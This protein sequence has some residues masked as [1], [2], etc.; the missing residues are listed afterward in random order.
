MQ[1]KHKIADDSPPANLVQT[2]I[3]ATF[4]PHEFFSRPIAKRSTVG[5]IAFTALLSIASTLPEVFLNIG[6]DTHKTS[7]GTGFGMIFGGLLFSILGVY[8]T[9][10]ILH[11]VLRV[12]GVGSVPRNKKRRERSNV[13]DGPNAASDPYEPPKTEV[14][15]GKTGPGSF[16]ET[17][18]AVAY[19]RAPLLATAFGNIGATIGL[20]WWLVILG[21]SL[22]RVHR[23]SMLRGYA[24]SL[25]VILGPVIFALGLRV[26]VVEAF[27]LPSGSMTPSLMIGD[28]IF[29]NKIAYGPLLPNSDTRILSRM[30]PKP[31]DVIVFKFPENKQQD[32]IK[33]VI[34]LPGDKLEVINGRPIINGKLVPHC[35]VGPWGPGKSRLYVE[36]LG[37]AAYFTIF[38]GD[39]RPNGPDEP[40][41]REQDDCT[42]GETCRAGICGHYQGPFKV[43]E[44]EVWV[45]GDN[46]YNSHDSRSWR[47]GIGAGVPFENIKGRASYVWMSFSPFGGVATRRIG[48]D[49]MGKADL[50]STVESPMREAVEKCLRDFSPASQTK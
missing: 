3:A 46:R 26:G 45:M 42:L 44:N 10:G 13:T 24:A 39:L 9:A 12:V 48:I 16:K 8:I 33:R 31:G 32:F 29:V 2:W 4:R 49:I 50:P 30:P 38:D 15:L 5:P 43:A 25:G 47:G 1:D 41:C 27:K 23:L 17:L 11:L 7:P 37:D 19:S 28:H 40:K 6:A 36:F 21:I 18:S 34:A 22:A 14:L 35:D 20:I